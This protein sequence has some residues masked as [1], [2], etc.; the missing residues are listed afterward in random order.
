MAR[1]LCC[2]NAF[3]FCYRSFV[4]PQLRG[5]HSAVEPVICVSLQQRRLAVSKFQDTRTV[6]SLGCIETKSSRRTQCEPAHWCRIIQMTLRIIL[7]SPSVYIY[8]HT[9]QEFTFTAWKFTSKFPSTAN[10]KPWQ[11]I[12]SPPTV[13]R[14]T[15]RKP[16][17][18]PSTLLEV[19]LH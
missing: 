13:H 11:T 8:T 16:L 14:A 19:G 2:V 3:R 12:H 4:L 6:T 18:D 5:T 9:Q 10:S 17:S 15:K 7:L 1:C